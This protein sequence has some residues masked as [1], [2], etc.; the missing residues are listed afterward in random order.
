MTKEWIVKCRLAAAFAL[1]A[2]GGTVA[3][4]DV[5]DLNAAREEART[6]L[7]GGF[8]DLNEGLI[9]LVELADRTADMAFATN[10]TPAMQ[11]I[12]HEG[13]F[14]MYRTAGALERAAE[15]EHSTV[16]AKN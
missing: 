9:R 2:C 5:A 4:T 15:S 10:A 1:A 7:A 8:S 16:S 14:N 3:A 12:L 13:A 11:R 6:T